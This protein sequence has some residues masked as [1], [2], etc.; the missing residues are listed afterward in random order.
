MET[1]RIEVDKAV[2]GPVPQLRTSLVAWR[3][4]DSNLI[5]L[6]HAI[7]R[8]ARMPRGGEVDKRVGSAAPKSRL[9]NAF[10]CLDVP[11]LLGVRACPSLALPESWRMQIHKLIGVVIPQGRVTPNPPSIRQNYQARAREF[12]PRERRRR[13]TGRAQQ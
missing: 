2:R 11:P 3:T 5:G 9:S 10:L 7:D 13:K 6:R 8:T 1:G 12:G 4:S